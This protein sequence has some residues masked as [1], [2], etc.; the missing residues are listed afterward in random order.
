M[1][2]R[3]IVYVPGLLPKPE[4]AVH[5]D[6]LWRCLAQGLV[7]YDADIA[8][9]IGRDD[10]ELF[11][12]T[13]GFYREH[14][15]FALDV[16]AVEDC[17]SRSEASPRDREE[18]RT[19]KRRLDGVARRAA[20]HLP[21]LIPR[22]ASERVRLHLADLA[23]YRGDVD[24]VA[25]RLRRDLAQTLLQGPD[26]QRV[27]LIGHSLGSV[28]CWDTLWQMSRERGESFRVDLWLTMGSPLGQR[29]VQHALCGWNRAGLERYPD[30]IRR[31]HNLSAVGDLTAAYPKLAPRFKEMRPLLEQ[32]SDEVVDNWFRLDGE[33]NPHAEYGYLA[34]RATAR[35]VA[36]W[37]REG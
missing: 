33:L 5:H 12:W 3:R 19:L 10:F 13:Y 37:W 16:A 21:F 30:N 25:T 17:A 2:S 22:L 18:A 28:I 27:L 9:E 14:R 7:H 24:G 1:T 36:G 32:Q 26:D 6:A 23:R 15:D 11:A 35:A 29:F 20:D 31:W 8:A 34:N 4:P